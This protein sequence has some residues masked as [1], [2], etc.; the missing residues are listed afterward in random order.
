MVKKGNKDAILK[1][2]KLD[3]F[4]KK[5]PIPQNEVSLKPNKTKL[6]FYLLGIDVE[7]K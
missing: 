5:D 4:I 6:N 1:F 3:F 2:I 7:I